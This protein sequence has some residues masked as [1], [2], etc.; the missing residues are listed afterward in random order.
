MFYV[1]CWCLIVFQPA[2]LFLQV[3]YLSKNPVWEQG[4][5]FFVQNVKTQ[6][7]TLQVSRE[8]PELLAWWENYLTSLQSSAVV[9]VFVPLKYLKSSTTY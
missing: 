7:L 8:T 5:N 2:I 6:Q 9:L 1:G 3:A 4:F